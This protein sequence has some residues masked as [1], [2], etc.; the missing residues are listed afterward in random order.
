VLCTAA[1]PYRRQHEHRNEYPA[2]IIELEASLMEAKAIAVAAERAT[3][4]PS[5]P[6]WTVR[7]LKIKEGA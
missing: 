2:D 1:N 5:S 6:Y 3:L 4:K 7:R